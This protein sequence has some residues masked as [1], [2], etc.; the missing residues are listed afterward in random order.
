MVFIRKVK[1]ASGATAIQIAHKT[2]SK[3][4]RIE[5]IGSAH[6]DAELALLLALARQRM[7]GSQ[8]ALL[9]D[10]DDS[11]NRVVLKRSSSELLWRTLVEQYRQLGFDQLK[12][13]DF[14]CLC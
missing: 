3:I 2:H 11:V 5:H 1:T 8:L 14:M 10:Q 9:N 4:S 13:E 7:R 12:D 6:T